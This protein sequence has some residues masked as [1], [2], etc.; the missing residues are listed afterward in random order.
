M[1]ENKKIVIYSDGGSRG[2]PGKAAIGI[3]LYA[4]DSKG[5][6]THVGDIKKYIGIKTNNFAEYTALIAGLQEAKNLGYKKAGC[7]LDSE[8]VVKQMNGLYRVKE[9]SLK[10]LFQEV[11]ELTKFFESATF[12]HVPRAKNAAADKLVNEA[13][14]S[15]A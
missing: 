6:L 13:L 5:N 15:I 4:E 8:L 7:F 2:N 14:D 11:K 9:E 1:T 12:M 10:P 3:V